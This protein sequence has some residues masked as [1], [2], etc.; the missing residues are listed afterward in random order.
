MLAL[1][2]P[3]V[4]SQNLAVL[5]KQ[6][7]LHLNEIDICFNLIPTCPNPHCPLYP[8]CFLVFHIFPLVILATLPTMSMLLFGFFA[9]S[10]WS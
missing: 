6:N 1:L 4:E 10:L 7:W 3:K 5:Y 8:C 2:H 9:S